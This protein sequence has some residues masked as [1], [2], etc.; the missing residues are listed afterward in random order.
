MRQFQ[1]GISPKNSSVVRT[2]E[3]RKCS[4]EEDCFKKMASDSD[5]AWGGLDML[6]FECI[7]KIG[8]ASTIYASAFE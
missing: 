6:A 1:R 7:S 2:A 4:T 5:I 3:E 8:G